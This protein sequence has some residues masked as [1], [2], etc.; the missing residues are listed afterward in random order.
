MSEKAEKPKYQIARKHHFV[1]EGYLA[2]FTNTGTSKGVL[3][4]YDHSTETFF[5]PKPKHIAFEIDYNRA[6]SPNYPLDA[7]ETRLVQFESLAIRELRKIITTG[8]LSSQEEFSWVYN[9]IALFAVKT[10]TVRSGFDAAQKQTVRAQAVFSDRNLTFHTRTQKSL[11][12]EAS[13]RSQYQSSATSSPSIRCSIR[14]C[15]TF[16]SDTGRS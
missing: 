6:D 13:T 5:R 7:L 9:L 8:K 11:L 2:G 4:A 15:R 1:S 3:C 10:P 16:P 14:F 12:H